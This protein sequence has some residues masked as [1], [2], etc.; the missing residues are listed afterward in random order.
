MISKTK[1]KIEN[2]EIEKIFRAAGI[3]GITGISPLG[4]GEY[5]A[6]FSVS[7]REKEYVL[8]I[9]PAQEAPVM[10]YEKDMMR[11]EVFWYRQ[12]REHTPITV[13]DVYFEDFERK[14]IP[15]DY[16]IMEKLSGKQ[17]SQMIFSV[18]VK[19][20][21]FSIT[22]TMA[23]QIQI[24]K[25]DRF[26]YLQNGLYDDWYQAIRA[27]TQSLLDDC[28][29][30]GKKSKRGKKLLAYIDRYQDILK[31][32]ECCMVNFDIW[33]PNIICSR[34]NG[35]VKY[36]WIDPERS[37]WGDR[38]ADFACLEWQKPLE[39]K[40]VSLAAYNAVADEPIRVT[41]EEKIRYAVMQGYLGLIQEVEKYYRYT[42]THFG[43]WRNV[44]SSAWFYQ[45]AFGGLK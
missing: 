28:A 43:W 19:V 33:W 1:Y 23:A 15:T 37:F 16:F 12:M 8:K 10:T 13:P 3:G 5:N 45:S 35:A 39:Q 31:K 7:T 20:M 18:S 40:K 29:R 4:A 36:A 32:A 41:R 2:K 6:V 34:E 22:A 9:A 30:V 26:G 11:A 14:Q 17:L 38:I 42:P 24:V 27:M 44:F 25:N 21:A